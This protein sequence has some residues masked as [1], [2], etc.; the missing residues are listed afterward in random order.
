MPKNVSP[1]SGSCEVG[2]VF[3]LLRS[4]CGEMLIK[5]G[6]GIGYF[7]PPVFSSSD[8]QLLALMT[9]MTVYQIF[10]LLLCATGETRELILGYSRLLW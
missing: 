8:H 5:L 1:L 7:L 3:S 2:E 9:T 4:A 6:D 10:L